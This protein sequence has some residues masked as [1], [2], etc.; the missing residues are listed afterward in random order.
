MWVNTG[1]RPGLI[2]GKRFRAAPSSLLLCSTKPW[3]R[4]MRLQRHSE[5][6]ARH[7][8]WRLK[9]SAIFRTSGMGLLFF[10]TYQP[11]GAVDWIPTLF[12]APFTLLIQPPLVMIQHSSPAPLA[13][14]R[15][16]SLWLTLSGRSTVS[17]MD[18]EQERP[19]QWAATQR[20][21]IREAIHGWYSVSYPKLKLMNIRYLTTLVA[22]ELLYD[23]LYQWDKQGQVNVT[24]T[25][26]PFFKDLSSNV[27]TGSYAK[28]SSAYE[29]LTS[30][31]KTYADG[32][33][34]VVQEYTPDG[35]A[36]AEQYSR[37]QGTPV[38]ASD[39]TWSYAAF[40]SAVGRR[41][42]TVPASWGSS[43]ANAVPSQCSGGTV[44]GSYTTPTVGSW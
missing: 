44:S 25:S 31:V 24:E 22:A 7:A 12:W 26:L 38:S 4:A 10:L 15:T 43:T 14:C 30:A 5:R 16:I 33:I 19:R 8:P 11:M 3:W 18:V 34:S 9:S 32:F 20:T 41:N 6:N 36:L 2:F 29:S 42:G 35:G 27:T 17:T 1:T 39:L 37:D 40:L 13:P 28:S 23:A 21:P